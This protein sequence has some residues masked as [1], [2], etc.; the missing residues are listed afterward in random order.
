MGIPT[1]TT[2]CPN[3]FKIL[4][5][6]HTEQGSFFG[7]S[8]QKCPYCDQHYIDPSIYEWVNLTE[9]EK[10]SVLVFG[11]N[12]AIRRESE[13]RS[14]YNK[15]KYTQFSLLTIP[16]VSKLKQQL[17]RLEQFVFHPRMLQ[18]WRIQES[19]ERTKDATY[20][21]TLLRLGRNYYGSDYGSSEF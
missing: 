8:M 15:W 19:I 16:I 18:D 6:A 1:Y 20:L 2:R 9:E 4:Q 14:L 3:C 10:K 17:E 21:N 12:R 13:I 5:H 11:W 7:N